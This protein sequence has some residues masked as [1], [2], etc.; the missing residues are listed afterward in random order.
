MEEP[1]PVFRSRDVVVQESAP[2]SATVTVP[3]NTPVSTPRIVPVTA[4]VSKPLSAQVSAPV[5]TPSS[6]PVP[7]PALASRPLSV[8]IR[9]NPP[10]R[11]SQAKRASSITTQDISSPKFVSSTNI[12]L[13]S[14]LPLSKVRKG[15]FRALK[16]QAGDF[17]HESDEAKNSDEFQFR[18]LPNPPAKTRGIKAIPPDRPNRNSCLEPS[19]TN[20]HFNP[21]S[22]GETVPRLKKPRDKFSAPL[23]GDSGVEEENVYEEI[24]G[25]S[26]VCPK[27]PPPDPPNSEQ[28]AMGSRDSQTPKAREEPRIGRRQNSTQAGKVAGPKR[29][30]FTSTRNGSE[31][32]KAK[33]GANDCAKGSRTPKKARQSTTGS[34]RSSQRTPRQ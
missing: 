1:V 16:Q 29:S 7:S 15:E 34:Q 23:L 26:V 32:A 6:A 12:N 3:M 2:A 17:E 21:T 30:D 8:V 18:T 33:P 13:E 27:I 24:G 28:K 20:L 31:K 11:A 19:S 22:T 4:P 14:T 25:L 9:P 10:N 5:I